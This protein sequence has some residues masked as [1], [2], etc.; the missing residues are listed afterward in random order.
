MKKYLPFIVAVILFI[1][2][3]EGMHAVM[4]SVFGEYETF[5]V[6]YYGFEVVFKTPV[7]EREGIHWGYISGASNAVTMAIGY[8]FFLYR[9][10][11]AR[12]ANPFSHALGYWIFFVFL[13]FDA[14]NLSVVPFIFNGDIGGIVRGFGVDRSLVQLLFFAVL[15][16]NREL[17][18]RKLFPLYGIRTKHLLFQPLW[19]SK[20]IR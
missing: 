5:R 8:I 2:I 10:K 3:H 13:L 12:L 6:H 16:I 9:E 14:L 15:L 11:L 19:G 20:S 4:A 17:I 7:A 18:V 1:V